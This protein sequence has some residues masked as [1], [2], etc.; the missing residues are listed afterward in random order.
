MTYARDRAFR[1]QIWRAYQ[2][3]A[4]GGE[5]D[6]GSTLRQIAVLRHQR[7]QLLGYETH[8][9]YVLEERMARDPQTVFSFLERLGSFARPQAALELEKLKAVAL[10]DGISELKP[11]DVA[12]YIEKVKQAEYD[13][14]EES[15]RPYFSLESVLEG[16]FEHARRLYGLEFVRQDSLP[17]YHPDVRVYE[18]REGQ[19]H[20]GLFYADFFP[21]KT[22]R[23]GAWMTAFR[24]QGLFDGQVKRPHV[25]IVCN[26]TP[27][28]SQA[29]ALL[30]YDEVRTLF[31]EFGHALHGLLS[32]CTYRSLAGTN[33]FWDFVELPSQLM[34]NWTEEKAALH[35]FARHYQTGELLPDELAD[36]IRLSSRLM[37][38][39]YC[40]RQLAFAYLDLAWHSRDPRS[41]G[42]IEAFESEVLANC[43][44]LPREPGTSI[45][46]SF[47]HIF[48]GGYSAGYY[49]Y[50]WAE[51][52]DAD[53]FSFFQEKGLF[54]REVA[55][56]FR[57]NVLSRGS[58]EHPSVLYERFRG[59]AP[60]T[61][62]LIRR[63]FLSG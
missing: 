31:H 57:A 34:E 46:S 22:K 45:S 54:D 53:A 10:P 62:A 4:L 50:K 18:V 35:L 26:F 13:F 32:E 56:R 58:T 21:R 63:D 6:N 11:W 24:D 42:D 40:L 23:G 17:V 47:S 36:K 29:P 41:V 16:A 33:V 44:V 60:D 37:A 7:A 49:S 5:Y 1:E 51:V 8:A 61:D 3:R 39:W 27:P 48:A 19:R 59:R 14:D 12:F 52:L 15:L 43:Q 25:A 38:G 20:L 28:T 55:S 9:H 30:S 2:S